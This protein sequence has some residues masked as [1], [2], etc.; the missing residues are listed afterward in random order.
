MVSIV[1]DNDNI[2]NHLAMIGLINMTN[3]IINGFNIIYRF[4][5]KNRNFTKYGER[6]HRPQSSADVYILR[7]EMRN[8]KPDLRT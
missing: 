1:Y 6:V 3:I 7:P 2:F 5:H 4:W 8:G